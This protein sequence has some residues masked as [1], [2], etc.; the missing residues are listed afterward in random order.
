MKRLIPVFIVLLISLTALPAMAGEKNT[1]FS[2][3]IAGWDGGGPFAVA[4]VDHRHRDDYTRHERERHWRHERRDHHEDLKRHK[5]HH[6]K[7]F[8]RRPIV[9]ERVVWTPPPRFKYRDWRYRGHQTCQIAK[10]PPRP[11]W[12]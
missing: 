10:R 7:H 1:F 12:W 8:K 3:S 5:K 2:F 6:R 4:K 11:Y 9:Y